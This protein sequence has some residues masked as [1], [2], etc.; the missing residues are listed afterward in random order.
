MQEDASQ[1]AGESSHFESLNA[2]ESSPFGGVM[3]VFLRW[4]LDL[5]CSKSCILLILF[6]CL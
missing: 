5:E 2:V 6:L 3:T 1:S 4:D